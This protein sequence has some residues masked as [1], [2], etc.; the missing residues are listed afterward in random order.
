MFMNSWGETKS[1]FTDLLAKSAMALVDT[2]KDDR[3][4]ALRV[5]MDEARAARDQG[6][7]VTLGYSDEHRKPWENR[8]KSLDV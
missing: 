3:L 5:S 6:F 7:W 1:T 2:E 4:G 8:R